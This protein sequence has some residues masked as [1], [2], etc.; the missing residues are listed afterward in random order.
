MNSRASL[1]C[2]AAT[3][4]LSGLLFT[5]SAFASTVELRLIETTDIHSNVLDFDFYRNAPTTR[6]GLVRAAT[7]VSEARAEAINSV[8]VD[9]GDLIQGS[10]MADWRASEGLNEG[11]THP[12]YKVMNAM[13]Y[14]V[15]NIGNHEFDFGLDFLH[16]AIEGSDFPYISANVYDAETKEHLF[17]PYIIKDMQV[18]DTDGNLQ[19]IKVGFIGFV[20]PQIM[21]WNRKNLEGKVF[22]TDITATARQLVPEM[23]S[24]GADVVVAIPHSGLSSE[25]Y[26]ALA[27]NSVY[28]LA[29]VP[30]ID[31]IMFGHSHGVFPS[32]AFAN[33][34]RVDVEAGTVNGIPTVMPGQWGSH[35]GVIDLTLEQKNGRWNI[36]STSSEVRAIAENDGTALVDADKDL[37]QLVEEDRIATSEFVNQPIGKASDIMY[38]YLALVQDDPTI[39]IVN[40]AQTEYVKHFIQGD[41]DLAHLP[42]LSAGAPFKAGGRKND[43]EGYTEVEAGV[44]TF[45]NAADLY[46]YPNTLSVLKVSGAELREWLEMAAGQ[47]T[48]ID[49]NS[50]EQQFLLNWD[51]FRTYNFDVIDGVE[52]EID[53]TQPWRYNDK[54]EMVTP[55][56]RRIKNLTWNGK[57]VENNQQ[58]LVATNNYRASGGGNFPG[59]SDSNLAFHSPDESRQ[60]LANYIS[61]VSKRDGQVVPTADNNW[62]IAPI[63]TDVELNVVFETSPSDK[64]ASFIKERAQYPM[65]KAGMEENGFAL[66]RIDLTK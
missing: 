19:S 17:D 36:V 12:V 53:V 61:E 64:A 15:G 18:T 45:S 31:A 60:V 42:V 39:Q 46:L 11:D 52:Y 43:P 2:K 50:T 8:L 26:R 38:S 35:I 32:P 5:T 25:P 13:E 66:Y 14:T 57:P 48:Q 9:N 28:Y 58:F 54:G 16:K 6:F 29:D 34:P 1:F 47:F 22:A 55:N 37:A 10:P 24:K 41:P 40:Q 3:Y 65:E 49:P 27:E 7:L 33:I 59:T 63:D 62:R 20:P 51:G 30:N 56:T 21:Q 4:T 23:K 44:V